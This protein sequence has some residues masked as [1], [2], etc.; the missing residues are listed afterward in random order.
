[1]IT[2][3]NDLPDHVIGLTA[4]SKV[5][6][7]DYEKIL[8]PEVEAKLKNHKKISLL[9]CLGKDFDSFSAGRCGTTPSSA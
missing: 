9:Y 4:S 5:T 2:L 7:E 3:M 1:M 6:G 8:I